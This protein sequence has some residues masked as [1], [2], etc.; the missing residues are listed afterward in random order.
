[1]RTIHSGL[2]VVILRAVL[3]LG[4]VFLAPA[5]AQSPMQC[6]V[7]GDRVVNQVDV[8]LILAALNKPSLGHGDPRDADG[9]G[10]I[11]QND[12]RDCLQMCVDRACAPQNVAPTANAGADQ[13]APLGTTVHLSGAQST[14]P[15][16]PQ[17]LTYTWRMAQRPA[18]SAAGV[19][20]PAAVD[21]TFVVDAPGAYILGLVVHDGLA[22]SVEDFVTV[23]TVN[24]APVANAGPDQSVFVGDKVTLNASGSTD[25]DG[26]FIASYW[27]FV[28]KPKGST[29]V[30]TTN[31]KIATA[32]FVVDMEGTYVVQLVVSDGYSNSAPDVVLIS[33]GN[34]PPV[35]NPKASCAALPNVDCS[36]P[37][38][39]LV[40]MDGSAS[41][42]VDGDPLTYAWALVSRPAG[43]AAAL[44]T[45]AAITAAFTTDAPGL[46]VV[47]LIVNDGHS[48][49][50][51]KTLNVTSTNVAPVAAATISPISI[52]AVP[53]QVQ[54]DGSGSLDPEG[55]GL[56]YAWSLLARP[57]GSAAVLSSSTA[58]KPTFV[59]D[60][61]G[62][63]TAQLIVNDGF[64]SST[65][66]TVSASTVN[67]PPIA[68][69]G[70]DQSVG[71]GATVQLTSAGSSDPEGSPLGYFWSMLNKPAG[72]VADFVNNANAPNPT[73]VADLKGTYVAQLIV[74]D[75]VLNSAPD[76]VQVTAANR[77][78]VA[79][80]DSYTVAQGGA[81]AVNAA[82]GVLAND[83]DADGDALTAIL[84][85]ATPTGLVFNSDG[86]FTYTPPAGFSGT[87]TF[88]Y[89]ANDGIADSNTV[90]V[91]ITV[92]PGLPTV[93]V[94][95][96]TPT[97]AETGLVPGVF[98]FTRTG[99]STFALDVS[100]S[101]GGTASNAGDYQQ[102]FGSVHFNAGQTTATQTVTPI[103]DALIEPDET[104]IV[105]I[106][107]DPTHYL[108]GSPGAA[109][110]TISDGAPNTV[111]VVA[112]VPN[113][114]ETGLVPGEFT[115]TR[116][117]PSTFA[118]D[119]SYS[120]GGTASNAGDYQ[121]LFGSVHFNAGQTTATQTVTPIADALIEPDETVIVTINADPTHYLIG[122]PGA[123]T[124]TISDG[125]PNT[126]TVVATVPNAAETGLV[127][128]EFTFTRTGP[129]T[130]ALDVSYSLGGTASNAGDYQQLFGSVH[131]NAGQTTATQTV[132][133]IADALIEP[134]ET[135]IVTISA[136]PTRYLIG[137]PGA[138]TVTISDGAPN[139]VTVVAT[140]PNAAETG[141]V[142][143]EFTFTRTGPSTFA[144]DVSYSLGGTA[145]NAGDYQQLFGSVHFN[146]GQ[147]TATQTV[148]PIADAL[149]EPDETVIVTISASPTR[150]LIGS[151]GAATVTI[152]DGA[153]NTVTVVAT[154]PNAA[155]T[156]LVP[157]EFTFTRTGPSTFA[158]D[159]SYSLGGTASNAGDYQQLFGSVHFNAGQ[160]TATQT[161]TP[162][163]DALI[164]PDETVI[165]TISASPTRYLIGSPSSATVTISDGVPNTVTIVATTPNASETGPVNGVFTVTRTGPT[166]FALDVS[167]SLGGT[168]SNAGD[169]QQLFGSVHFN[170][171][172]ATSTITIVPIPDGINDP[173][174]TV[175][176]TI[177]ASPT[178]YL[179]GSPSSDTVTIQ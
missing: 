178:R 156:G 46:F 25:V 1:M 150:Y 98:T 134:D 8:R 85:G 117:G 80:D 106:N 130:F 77:A 159:V 34:T 169:Y 165:V 69:A 96:T 31:P 140:V 67:Q 4:V 110:V 51:P 155:E 107:A 145:S 36:V 137:S 157:G 24:S 28:A 72:S 45:P 179:I 64:L 41:T 76:T 123:A 7:N 171:G 135:V 138:A 20:N 47:Q 61:L 158:L 168:A 125:A 30:L 102:L 63:Y 127:P 133:P 73:F 39:T 23:S 18:A 16:G 177:S 5:W 40:T 99:P 114:A 162:I 128:G 121:Q 88:Q 11:T 164:E 160:T 86:S 126:V 153:P 83:S 91:T 17:P 141:L 89:K 6:D 97:A 152:S 82:T 131:F 15:D 119:V 60:V 22:D 62:T 44:S 35:A 175:I 90:T 42:D 148:T 70:P 149:I 56:T 116:T 87:T 104:V 142:P 14:D 174:E 93:T 151:P 136:S 57:P 50:A 53:Q 71:A 43:S 65:P 52:P 2:A 78:P 167:Y 75:G 109:T 79:V 48:D 29:A 68:N 19:S 124:V 129:S 100:Y 161:V 55:Q 146:A 54:L 84:V 94:V 118:L 139:T 113:A 112:T 10:R 33:T 37:I 120:L 38:G 115:F 170:A 105:T 172:Q 27:T 92:T 74:N 166:A 154:V 66:V 173:N 59:A 81:L 143:G 49:S 21:P 144:L 147:T 13:S 176:V 163:A 103:A 101:L 3:L 111:T 95:A 122:S 26:D 108:I 58:V 32:T 132:T 9:D 12:V